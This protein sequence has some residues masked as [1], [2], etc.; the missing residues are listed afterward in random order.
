MSNIYARTEQE[1]EICDKLILYLK[2]YSLFRNSDSALAAKRQEKIS[3]SYWTAP[4]QAIPEQTRF[5]LEIKKSLS[6]PVGLLDLKN[7]QFLTSQDATQ[8]NKHLD[9]K[10]EQNFLAQD[11]IRRFMQTRNGKNNFLKSPLC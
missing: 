1:K 5:D 8:S 3:F 10:N 11:G 2:Q 7:L 9:I 4:T 6:L